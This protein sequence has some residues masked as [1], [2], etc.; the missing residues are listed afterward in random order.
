MNHKPHQHILRNEL[1]E[2]VL[3]IEVYDDIFS[4]FD[5]RPYSSRSLSVDFLDEIKRATRD[6]QDDGIVLTMCVMQ[7]RSGAREFVIRERLLSHFRKY[8]RR[9][10]AEKRRLLRVGYMM[11]GLG[12]LCMITASFIIYKTHEKNFVFSVLLLFLEP[13]AWFLLWEGMDQLIFNS[14][15][16]DQ[17]LNFYHKMSDPHSNIRFKTC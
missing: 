12:A 16:L 4:D 5:V 3:R 13:A 6:K 14:K 7:R 17:D 2:I 9:L 8:H 10:I 15:K 1:S 11:V